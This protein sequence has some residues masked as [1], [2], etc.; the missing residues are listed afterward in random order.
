MELAPE[1]A[2]D[3]ALV[4]A[5]LVAD[6]LLLFDGEE[7]AA[8]AISAP[9]ETARLAAIFLFIHGLLWPGMILLSA[10]MHWTWC[11]WCA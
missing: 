6:E 2:D 3:D 1:D 4:V 8:S 10:S 5:L 11:S 7:H 9:A